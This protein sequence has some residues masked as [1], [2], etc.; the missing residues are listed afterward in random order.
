M[1]KIL[2]YFVLLITL[3]LVGFIATGHKYV[4]TA[5]ART[6]LV[7]EV[8]AN[9][10][11]HTVFDTRVIANGTPQRWATDQQSLARSLPLALATMSTLR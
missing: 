2:L 3:A 1:K 9:V 8:T 6:Y 5:F 10:D 4:L 11:D 7:G